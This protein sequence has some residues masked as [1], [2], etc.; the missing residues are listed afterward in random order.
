MNLFV[1][2]FGHFHTGIIN[3]DHI[4]KI[5]VADG[6]MDTPSLATIYF[7]NGDATQIEGETVTQLL[8]AIKNWKI[9]KNGF[10]CDL[11]GMIDSA[12]DRD[13]HCVDE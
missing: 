5:D 2:S 7:E 13:S 11:D 9:T 3:L 4:V 10:V 6:D 8:V 12:L 1:Y